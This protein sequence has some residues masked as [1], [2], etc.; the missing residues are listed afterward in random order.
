MQKDAE[1]LKYVNQS[2]FPLQIAIE[3][4]FEDELAG[5]DWCVSHS[6]HAW[7]NRRNQQ[8]GFIDLV[9]CNRAQTIFLVV[10]CKRRLSTSWLFMHSDGTAN[11]V[12]RTKT[13]VSQFDPRKHAG[14][15][16]HLGWF[17]IQA[18]PAS[19]VAMFCCTR[20][21]T[22]KDKV[23]M[24]ERDCSE[25][26]SSTEALAIEEKKFGSSNV[27]PL[28]LYLNVIVTTAELKVT[29]FDPYGISLD[30]GTIREAKFTSV[31]YLR[32][33]KQFSGQPNFLYDGLITIENPESATEREN[34]VF[35]V[36]ANQFVNFLKAF[37]VRG[38]S[39]RQ[40]DLA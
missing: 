21:Q 11:A 28:R 39:L 22:D 29:E 34:T 9:I 15:Y 24:L 3:R 8:S 38:E 27:K 16:S 31:P 13:W 2:G 6:E 30:D 37:D 14:N 18:D 19:P 33:R 40:F 10:E 12:T 25:L 35:I 4:L 20:G 26:I 23:N 5:G 7:A 32:F 36:R 1:S 17:D